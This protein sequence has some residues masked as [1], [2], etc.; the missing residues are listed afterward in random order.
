MDKHEEILSQIL[1]ADTLGRMDTT[2]DP[3]RLAAYLCY[4][5]ERIDGIGGH[6]RPLPKTESVVTENK[7]GSIIYKN[8]E[9]VPSAMNNLLG[10]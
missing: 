3:E 10:Q 7:D 1:G 2:V 6:Y 9:Y 5:E 4:L 8:K